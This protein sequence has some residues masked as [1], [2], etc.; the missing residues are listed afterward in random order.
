MMQST[1]RGG[2]PLGMRHICT[3]LISAGNHISLGGLEMK[4]GEHLKGGTSSE[5]RGAKGSQWLT[6]ACKAKDQTDA[7]LEGIGWKCTRE[8]SVTSLAETRG[9]ENVHGGGGG[10]VIESSPSWTS[11]RSRWCSDPT[12]SI[13]LPST[14][15]AVHLMNSYIDM[16]QL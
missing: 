5:E 6:D 12:G 11:K 2:A 13:N 1:F 10:K 15:C 3:L 4:R 9:N 14:Y 7:T 8:A 16:V